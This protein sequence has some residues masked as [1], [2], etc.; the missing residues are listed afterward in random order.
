M[1]CSVIQPA[2]QLFRLAFTANRELVRWLK[3]R[4][5]EHRLTCPS[6]LC[7][8]IEMN[9]REGEGRPASVPEG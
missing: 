8:Q 6:S 9:A 1:A 7:V 2:D 5:D 4:D 3:Q